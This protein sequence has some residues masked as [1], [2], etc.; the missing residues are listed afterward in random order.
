VSDPS[1][2]ARASSRIVEIAH[3]RA[4]HTDAARG[5]LTPGAASKTRYCASLGRPKSSRSSL[6]A[7]SRT[8]QAGLRAV[9]GIEVAD[10]DSRR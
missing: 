8:P 2:W 3:A 9:D 4:I 7:A 10:Q 5:V 1:A 6:E